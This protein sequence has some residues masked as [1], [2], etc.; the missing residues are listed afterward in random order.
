MFD[1]IG[2]GLGIARQKVTDERAEG[3]VELAPGLAGDRIEDDR[4][5]AGA[6]YAGK[7]GDFTLGDTQRHIFQIVFAGTTDL[8]IL[9]GPA[10]L[11]SIHLTPYPSPAPGRGVGG[12]VL[13]RLKRTRERS[14]A[15][16]AS[17]VRSRGGAFVDSAS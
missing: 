16:S 12:E 8:D 10:A 3:I 17:T 15:L 13:Q 11:P 9:L 7:N 5:F 4:G 14:R 6:G 2:I 1:R